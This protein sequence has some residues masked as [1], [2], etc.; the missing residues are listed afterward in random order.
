[1]LDPHLDQLYPPPRM[2]MWVWLIIIVCVTTRVACLDSA[3]FL[4]ASRVVPGTWSTAE[5]HG[6]RF[7]EEHVQHCTAATPWF[8]AHAHSRSATQG[9]ITPTFTRCRFTKVY[10]LTLKRM[11][12]QLRAQISVVKPA[13]AWLAYW[14][15]CQRR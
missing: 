4:Q 14:L 15:E 12:R 11:H 8:Y 7:D 6:T 5:I 3:E 2:G 1:M 9:T 10:I 13:I